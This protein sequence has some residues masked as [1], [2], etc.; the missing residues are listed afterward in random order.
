MF[1]NEE[2]FDS[3]VLNFSYNIFDVNN[4]FTKDEL[5]ITW[6]AT[7]EAKYVFSLEDSKFD[8]TLLILSI[9]DILPINIKKAIKV[10]NKE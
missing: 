3:G 5:V 4:G 6:L 10:N 7:I 2:K 8:I 9:E 1:Y